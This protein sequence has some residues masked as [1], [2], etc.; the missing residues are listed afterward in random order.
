M[1]N[2]VACFYFAV[3]LLGATG[4]NAQIKFNPK[5]GFNASA[6]DAK[7]RNITAEARYGWNLGMD[8]RIGKSM[9]F[10][11]PGMH[12]Y[13]FTADL[14]RDVTQPG[15]IPMKDETTVQSLKAP[16]N[17]GL[18]ITGEGG[19]VGVNLHGG[20][21]PSYILGVRERN[22]VPFTKDDVNS[23][24]WGANLGVG[25][26]ILLFTVEANYE[27]GLSPFFNNANGKNNVLTV[28]AGV[29]F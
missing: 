20:V 21:T 24:T 3:A 6:I 29:K 25:I 16:I 26:D 4:V 15:D 13:N 19:I 17:A 18:R 9:L 27:I 8:L 2:A 14:F 7:F 5:A 11:K 10:F 23:L 12:Y 28:S 22:V 1:K